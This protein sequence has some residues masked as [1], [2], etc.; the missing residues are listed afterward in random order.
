MSENL[1]FAIGLA[2]EAG[3]TMKRNFSLG[4]KKE[5]KEDETPVTA[6]DI[7]INTLVLNAVAEKYPSHSF[8]GEEG[9]LLKES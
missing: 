1:E 6:T 3:G 7:E 4:M 9:S 2:R 8:V 5:W